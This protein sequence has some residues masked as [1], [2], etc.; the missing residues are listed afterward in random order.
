MKKTVVARAHGKLIVSGEYSVL[1]KMPAIAF[2]IAECTETTASI[3]DEDAIVIE[4]KDYNFV[5]QF[6]ANSVNWHHLRTKERYDNFLSGLLP[7]EQVLTNPMD[8]C[9]FIIGQL[10]SEQAGIKV[11]IK[12]TIPTA[13]GFGSSAAL[14]VSLI[15][16]LDSLFEVNLTKDNFYKLAL[17]AENLVH[18]N[19]SGID[20]LT[21]II[22]GCNYFFNGN[23]R[24]N[25]P[26]FN[27]FS[28]YTGRP[29]ISSGESIV[30]V[31]NLLNAVDR[32]YAFKEVTLSLK[33]AFEKQDLLNAMNQIR[34]NHLLLKELGV[35]PKK[36]QDFIQEIESC[37]GAAKI[38]GSGAVA[39]E[40][41]GA[42]IALGNFDDINAIALRFNYS[43][44]RVQQSNMGAYVLSN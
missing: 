19:S 32:Q 29:D 13:S 7:I 12:S 25:C 43:I 44:K 23:Y 2:A 11:S 17:E 30:K 26:E 40:N 10:V 22:G 36:V 4:L 15:K 21:S 42:V 37:S 34:N 27:F 28:I 8:L 39:G 38:C 35:V 6:S 5:M 1:F 14:I 16:S 20:L 3:I 24:I 18:G 33:E 41:A 9:C 31:K